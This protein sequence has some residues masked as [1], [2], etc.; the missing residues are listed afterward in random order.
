MGLKASYNIEEIRKAIKDEN[1]NLTDEEIKEKTN[2]LFKEIFRLDD[3]E[4]KSNRRYRE[5][6]E[7]SDDSHELDIFLQSRGICA[8]IDG[9]ASKL[10]LPKNIPVASRAN[11]TD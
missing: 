8:G 4:N 7:F 1:P 3:Q 5:W 6:V 2:F 10:R 9:K 11:Q